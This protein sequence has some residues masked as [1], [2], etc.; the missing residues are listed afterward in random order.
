MI[1]QE[2]VV[3]YFIRSPKNNAPVIT[4]ALCGTSLAKFARGVAICH[5]SD[6][7]CKKV[8]RSIAVARAKH[9]FHKRLVKAPIKRETWKT[10][11]LKLEDFVTHIDFYK[12][13][14]MPIPTRYE[15][16]LMRKVW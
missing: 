12:M 1:E 10:N 2:K 7:V 9:A 13:C 15:T 3:H 11:L 6:Q 4:V 14:F 5:D 8:G 16:D